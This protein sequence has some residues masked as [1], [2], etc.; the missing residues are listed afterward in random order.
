MTGAGVLRGIAIGMAI[1][2]ILNPACT[3]RSE[4]PLPVLVRSG[5]SEA[6]DRAL[7]DRVRQRLA[8]SMPGQLDVDSPEPPRAIVVTG[9]AIA[10]D[11]LPPEVPVSTVTAAAPTARNVGIHD[12]SSSPVMLAGWTSSIVATVVATQVAGESSIIILEHEGIE[13]GRVDH[14]W[15][16]DIETFEARFT[17]VPPTPGVR[18][19]RI[20]AKPLDGEATAADNHADL[21]LM[22]ED[23][24]L[25]VLVHEPRPSWATAFIR[26][27]LEEEPLLDVAGLARP[28]RGVEVR[29]GSAP[30]RLG[31]DSV[32]PFD[33]VVVGAP[34]DLHQEEIEVLER[35]ARVRG[36]TFVLVPDRRP[37]GAYLKLI[38]AASFEERLLEN[39]VIAAGAGVNLRG[40]EFAVAVR[41][42]P[43]VDVIASLKQSKGEEPVIMA[44]PMGAG[45]GMFAGVLD[46]WR[47]RDRAG[48]FAAFWRAHIA[49]AGS[50]SPRRVEASL[51]PG[52]AS[53]G[54]RVTLHVRLRP[55]EFS[56]EQ[57]SIELPTVSASLT[58]PDGSIEPIRLWASAQSGSF[59]GHFQTPREGKFIVKASAGPGVTH[60]TALIVS[61]TTRAPGLDAPQTVRLLSQTTGGIAVT[62]ED[63]ARLEAHLAGLPLPSIDRSV[64]PARSTLWV[65]AFVLL[66]CAEWGVRRRGGRR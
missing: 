33:V 52:I 19:M 46:A 14:Q 4:V 26:R 41:P 50:A 63:L 59:A 34:E 15:A 32:T 53:P 43:A 30:E 35:F 18:A 60:E 48:E 49:S 16:A 17:L 12:V 56:S 3:R 62:E 22:V 47:H 1:I 54:Q 66:L 7:A 21:R 24:Q 58:H 29:A 13:L 38:P 51:I 37:A 64:H 42:A 2:A 9:D 10:I 45:R 36:G 44:W 20:V 31:F 6:S 23:R 8:A 65:T 25:K 39:P 5:S 57:Q 61:N 28:S 11:D 40:S 27:V 55:T